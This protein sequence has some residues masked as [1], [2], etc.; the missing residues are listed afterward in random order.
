MS[1]DVTVYLVGKG[2]ECTH[3]A[4]FLFCMLRKVKSILQVGTH[5]NAYLVLTYDGILAWHRVQFYVE[6]YYPYQ[7]ILLVL[8]V[9]FSFPS[10]SKDYGVSW[11]WV[12]WM[13]C[14]PIPSLQG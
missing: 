3:L 14:L 12:H 7:R 2:K 11:A 4:Q 10:A 9:C 13:V 1:I 8:F 5:P 6:V